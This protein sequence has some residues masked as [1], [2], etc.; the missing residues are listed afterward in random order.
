MHSMMS[1]LFSH[2]KPQNS[3]IMLARLQPLQLYWCGNCK[4]A[5][6]CGGK[7]LSYIHCIAYW[8]IS[9]L[10][11]AWYS[12]ESIYLQGSAFILIT[13]SVH[14]RTLQINLSTENQRLRQFFSWRSSNTLKDM[15][16]R[17]LQLPLLE[18]CRPSVGEKWA[19]LY[20]T[21]KSERNIKIADYSVIP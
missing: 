13:F 19:N 9:S 5:M 18:D 21:C 10:T 2:F 6:I 16:P 15:H 4:L 7:T 17:W 3:F 11:H 20:R 14:T 8:I 1:H 12:A